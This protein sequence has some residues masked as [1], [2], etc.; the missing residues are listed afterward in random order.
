MTKILVKNRLKSLVASAFSRGKGGKTVRASLGKIILFSFL[1]LYLAAVVVGF[2]TLI[3]VSL[4]ATLIPLGASWLYFAVVS[5]IA[6][7]FIFVFGIFETKG[8]IFESKDNELLLS[9]PIKPRSIVGSR[10]AVVMIYNYIESIC[11]M[12]PSVIVYAVYSNFEIRGIIGGILMTVLIPMLS[13]ALSSGVGYVISMITRKMK[14]SSIASLLIATLFLLS[15]FYVVSLIGENAE[16]MLENIINNIDNIKQN[17]GIVYFIGQAVLL[18]PLPFLSILLLCVLSGALAYY[19]I[20][21]SY[22]KIVTASYAS[23]KVKYKIGKFY[24]STSL[25]ALTKKEFRKIASSSVYMLNGGIGLVLEVIF[26]IFILLGGSDFISTVG[27]I[28]INPELFAP[29]MIV[30]VAIVNSMTMFTASVVSLEGGG[31]WIIKSMPI[32]TRDVFLSKMLPQI[33]ISAIPTL[34]LSVSLFTVGGFNAYLLPFFIIAPQ[35]ANI[36]FAVLGIIFNVAFPKFDYDTEARVIKQSLP[37]FLTMI[38]NM[39]L[40]IVIMVL[41]IVLSAF[42]VIVALLVELFAFFVIALV[43][44]AILFTVLA[45]RYESFNA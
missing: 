6:L 37:V 32:R 31:L 3:A 15:Y 22:I 7:S 4:G 5:I 42:S 26:A 45:R 24:K 39:L 21:R 25:L 36:L 8:E 41:S 9:M 20:S 10:I 29:I 44:L 14:K 28:G 2:S 35:I 18:S 30:L 33:I 40:C 34:F 12:L 43:L 19:L 23:E 13:T 27:E 38:S 17:Y 11:I 16:K 1:Y